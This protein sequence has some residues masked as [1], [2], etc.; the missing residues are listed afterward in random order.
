MPNEAPDY[1]PRLPAGARIGRCTVAAFIGREPLG[2]RYAVHYG[3]T[4]HLLDLVVPP[5]VPG[6]PT[7]EDYRA[8][9]RS[10]EPVARH[11]ALAHRFVA[12]LDPCLPPVRPA[13]VSDFDYGDFDASSGA[14]EAPTPAPDPKR[15]PWM[16]MEH[17]AGV[18][19]WALRTRLDG[20]VVRRTL[21]PGDAGTGDETPDV[22]N[23]AL[24]LA[25]SRGVADPAELTCLLGDVLDA[26][27]SLHRAKLPGGAP[28]AS[29]IALDRTAHSSA[30]IAR[31][32]RYAESPWD[33]MSSARDLDAFSVL[34]REASGSLPEKSPVA[35]AYAKFADALDAGSFPTAVEA[36]NEWVKF[37]TDSGLAAEARGADPPPPPR[38]RAHPV[39][40]AR[41][42]P[43][44]EP[45]PRQMSRRSRRR[46]NSTFGF[47]SSDS[48]AM[49]RVR[50][51][52]GATVFLVTICAIGFGVWFYM[53]WS[54]ERD[55][56]RYAQTYMADAPVVTVIPTEAPGEETEESGATAAYRLSGPALAS[57][58]AAGEPF[59]R[60]R[61]ALNALLGA[62]PEAPTPEILAEADS[63]MA[64]ILPELLDTAA[65]DA[66]AAFMRGAGALL[67]LGRPR[68]PTVAWR[69]LEAS[70]NAG[71]PPA[72]V[73]FG[74]L[75][76]GGESCAAPDFA[77]KGALPPDFAARDRRAVGYYRMA[78]D[79]IGVS[80]A[81]RA[82]A[83]GRITSLLRR[84]PKTP[85]AKFVEELRP[86][87]R[88][89][90]LDGSVPAMSLMALGG[91]F[92]ATN[93][94]E[95]LDWLR[96]VNR[97]SASSPAVKAWA[98]TRMAARFAR[99]VGTPA[100]ESAARVWYERAAMLGNGTAMRRWADYLESGKGDANGL[101][102][103]HAAAEW[104]AKAE[105]AEPEPDFQ[106]AWWPLSRPEPKKGK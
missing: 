66:A 24:F 32:V 86:V 104:R 88:S 14:D 76:C 81:L 5:D 71:F 11:P 36:Y 102:N 58:A 68:E 52:F 82:A 8:H 9:I 47:L 83:I 34:L 92:G 54:D 7:L 61:V 60:A 73:L 67:A 62:A 18:P 17:V 38:P 65:D 70:A 21:L 19:Q 87:V 23:L 96:R 59:A 10:L 89:A 2:E 78:V 30:P 39:R 56:E 53:T 4:Q 93:A 84:A 50:A 15:I 1:S 20:D 72:A 16:R 94:V 44:P 45:P 26:L 31:L 28:T 79:S 69:E 105:Q 43:P 98:Q 42:T 49:R 6:A 90:A 101:G 103:P 106:P 29:D 46:G 3:S 27:A 99:G 57:A 55:R 91:N 63:A 35:D 51:F 100:S 97:S 13:A 41:S 22:P 64:A 48:E 77:P 74:D 12:G 95:A 40:H 25:A 75:V 33:G 80:P 85:P 37:A